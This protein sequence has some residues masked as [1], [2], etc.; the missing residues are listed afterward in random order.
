MRHSCRYYRAWYYLLF[1]INPTEAYETPPV[2]LDTI[3]RPKFSSVNFIPVSSWNGSLEAS[4]TASAP[5]FAS[6]TDDDDDDSMSFFEKLAA[7]D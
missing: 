2:I 7:D 6:K 4:K 1:S 3:A 5:A